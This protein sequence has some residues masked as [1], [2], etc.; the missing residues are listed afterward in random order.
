MF[1]IKRPQSF[2]KSPGL[3][4]FQWGWKTTDEDYALRKCQ[5]LLKLTS[6]NFLSLTRELEK[7][8]WE[9]DLRE[10]RPLVYAGHVPSSNALGLLW[11]LISFFLFSL[12]CHA[13]CGILVPLSGIE[14]VPLAVEARSCDC[15]TTKEVP[16][17]F[18]SRAGQLLLLWTHSRPSAVLVWELISLCLSFPP[19][20]RR[21]FS[22]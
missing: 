18:C 5:Q 9:L 16:G 3:F 22:M 7:L 6:L 11:L 12:L 8:K 13:A 21:L 19:G 4:F 17:F 2:R 15:W 10:E 1:W 20:G 14:P